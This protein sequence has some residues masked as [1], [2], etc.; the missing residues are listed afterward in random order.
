MEVSL[1]KRLLLQWMEEGVAGCVD[2]VRAVLNAVQGNGTYFCTHNLIIS[3]CHVRLLVVG[4]W[5]SV[6]GITNA[7]IIRICIV[8]QELGMGEYSHWRD[9]VWNI[10]VKTYGSDAIQSTK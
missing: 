2:D 7:G 10:A 3:Y 6:L 9:T 4:R 1:S 8:C 5:P